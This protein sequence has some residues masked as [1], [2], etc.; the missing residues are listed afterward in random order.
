MLISHP[1][2]SEHFTPTE[3][4]LQ[5]F[6]DGRR[7]LICRDSEFVWFFVSW[8]VPFDLDDLVIESRSGHHFIAIGIKDDVSRSIYATRSTEPSPSAT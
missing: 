5:H 8:L 1:G 2:V 3:R 7:Q 6:D 4:S